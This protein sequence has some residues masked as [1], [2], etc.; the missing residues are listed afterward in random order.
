VALVLNWLWQGSAVALVTAVLLAL[1]R[2]SSARDRYLAV[3]VALVSVL[4]LPIVQ[5]ASQFTSAQPVTD[6]GPA[7]GG[8]LLEMPVAWWTSTTFVLLLWAVWL[9][10]TTQRLMRS[11]IVLWRVKRPLSCF[12]AF[13]Q[14]RLT[15]WASVRTMGRSVQLVVCPG[16]RSAAVL[17]C[18]APAIALAPSLLEHLSDEELDRIVIHEW[19]HVQRRDDWMQLLQSCITV[20]VG[21]H[22]AIWWLDRQLRIER[23]I[24]CD[25]VA[26]T[27]TG[28]AKSYAASLVK[29]ASL[30]VARVAGFQGL[31][32]IGPH[33]LRHR[34]AQ[35][36][37]SDRRVASRGWRA[38][39]AAAAVVLCLV[40]LTLGDI[41]A[42]EA[43]TAIVEARMQDAFVQDGRLL[44]TSVRTEP[45]VAVAPAASIPG[46]GVRAAAQSRTHDVIPA[47]SDSTL[48]EP[49]Q[50]PEAARGLIVEKIRGAPVATAY[51]A[52]AP[53]ISAS[54]NTA[55]NAVPIVP[56]RV[57]ADEGVAIG[58]ES[59][60]AAVA[61]ASY[62]TRLGKRIAG[63]F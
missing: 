61:T 17:G 20:V 42:I 30:P 39:A 7:A 22:P 24:A 31:A 62:F 63:S 34:V 15:H 1:I 16:V 36:L 49:P 41:R 51:N 19:A 23:E 43:A 57:A 2:R 11:A 14:D 60:D 48:T 44:S 59:R 46:P 47:A 12:P 21:W 27:I 9:A 29:L 54:G 40:A 55:S 56:W 6:A 26:V 37:S 35:I 28:S 3:W 25:E 10:F 18:G 38:A 32:A 53:S 50:V 58:R 8:P 4:A 52:T 5:Y 13:W 45:S 33:G